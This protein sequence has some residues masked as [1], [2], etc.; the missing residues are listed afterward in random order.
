VGRAPRRQPRS[1]APGTP[2]QYDFVSALKGRNNVRAGALR[3]FGRRLENLN[4]ERRRFSV[5]LN[6]LLF[7][8][9]F[10]AVESGFIYSPNGIEDLC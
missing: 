8:G 9:F 7:G 2:G 3:H 5:E 6:K 4:H 1:A 10:L